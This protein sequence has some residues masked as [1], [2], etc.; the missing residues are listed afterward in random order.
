[1]S[2]SFESGEARCATRAG[3]KLRKL[4]QMGDLFH[5]AERYPRKTT[6]PRI[7]RL[8]AILRTG[9]VAPARSTDGSVVSDIKLTV[10]GCRPPY[11]DFVFLHRF[12]PQS[13]LYTIS[14]P[15]RFAVFIDP[16]LPVLTPDEMGDFWPELCQDEVYVR[17]IVPAESFVAVAVH[18]ADAETVVAEI[19]SELER[20]AVPL[21]DY[22]GHVLWPV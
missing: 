13:W 11:E 14:E 4:W 12:G 8:P 10:I 20:L 22:E 6:A 16:H 18:P 15:G 19:V 2:Q 1:M 5:V 7:D 17:G 21:Y 9:L 3:A